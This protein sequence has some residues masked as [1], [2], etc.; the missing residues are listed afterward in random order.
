MR[1]HWTI[2]VKESKDYKRDE[3]T[4]YKIAEIPGVSLECT[5]SKEWILGMFVSQQWIYAKWQLG[6]VSNIY[7]CCR[8]HRSGN[9][10]V[11]GTNLGVCQFVGSNQVL[12]RP[13][14]EVLARPSNQVLARPS[15]QVLARP[16]NSSLSR[17]TA[18]KSWQG[19]GQAIKPWQEGQAIKPWP[20][21]SSNQVLAERVEQ[22]EVSR[23]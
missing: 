5:V 19:E 10:C 3:S 12:A 1:V 14:N 6:L 15:N 16:S 18:I 21:W 4:D 9:A 13:S 22:P 7:R 11:H 8:A 23:Q 17:A 20:R 2:K